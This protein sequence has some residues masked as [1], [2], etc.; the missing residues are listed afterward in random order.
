ME[1]KRKSK[2]STQV[3]AK[4]NN[5]VYDQVSFRAPKELVEK[6]KI[7]CAEAG[8]SQAQIFKKAM[9]DFLSEQ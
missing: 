7:K 6:F 2:T 8:V 1:E 4:Y 9:E 5:K 3:K